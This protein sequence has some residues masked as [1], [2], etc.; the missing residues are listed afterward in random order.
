MSE[1]AEVSKVV[2][3]TA[4]SGKLDYV[5]VVVLNENTRTKLH[6]VGWLIPHTNHT[7]FS[8]KLEALVFLKPS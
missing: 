5:P 3:K 2:R 7:E 4:Q 8:I 6:V 1:S